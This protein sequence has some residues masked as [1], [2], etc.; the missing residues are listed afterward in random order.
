MGATTPGRAGGGGALLL[1][2]TMAVDLEL[3]ALLADSVD[4]H[5]ADEIRHLVVVPGAQMPL[6]RRFA[7]HRREIVAQEDVLPFRTF[8]APGALRHLS[9]LAEGF[10]R[11]I[12]LTSRL[13]PVRGWMLQQAIKIEA[14]R[15]APEAAVIHCDSDMAFVRALTLDHVMPG[16]VPHFFATPVSTLSAGHQGWAEQAARL[17]GADLPEDFRK[18]YIENAIVWSADEARAMIRR[19]EER[20]GR[21]IHDVVMREASISEYY[22]YG[23]HVERVARPAAV[24]PRAF[25]LCRTFWSGAPRADDAQRLAAEMRP[26]HVA[27]ALQSTRPVPLAERADLYA[28]IERALAGESQG[29]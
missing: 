17:L 22:L 14:T 9:F 13:R 4:R 8:K 18:T 20:A 10:R 12:Y 3:F 15:A 21:P 16:G 7:T 11:P 28:C 19:I 29:A 5:V 23:V 1:T 27:V 26:D 25:P 24:S 2:C 6:F